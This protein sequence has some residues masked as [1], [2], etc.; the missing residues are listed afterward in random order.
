MMQHHAYYC[1]CHFRPIC[2][3][4]EP[5]SKN[6]AR[7]LHFSADQHSLLV[8]DFQDCRIQ[9]LAL[10]FRQGEALE[11]SN[12]VS[13]SIVTMDVVQNIMLCPDHKV[14]VCRYTIT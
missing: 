9:L 7:V 12:G 10:A 5:A 4:P 14:S 6:S 8:Y 11:F 2:L 1:C 13:K 3:H